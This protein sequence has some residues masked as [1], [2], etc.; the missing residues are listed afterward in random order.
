M[1]N[2]TLPDDIRNV[3]QNQPVENI[4]MPLEEIRQKARQFEKTINRRNLGEYIGGAIGAAVYI[5]YIVKFDNLAIRAGSFLIIAGLLCSL[6]QIYKGASP[7]KLAAHLA[8]TASLEFH[9]KELMRQRDLLRS[10]WKWYIGPI[11]PG[12]VVFSAGAMP[13]R[14]L[15]LV[16]Y[17][18]VLVAVFGFIIW[19]NHRAAE[20]LDR[21]IA[22]LDNLE[23]H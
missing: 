7:R 15:G 6:V 9:R 19:A 13:R 10:V 3:W 20:R 5:F 22:E 2:E 12:L 1:P 14:G 16:L 18:S 11:V 8:L 23:S 17:V 4:S 21:Q